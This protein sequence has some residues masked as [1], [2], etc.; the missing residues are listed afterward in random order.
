M[1][2]KSV[3]YTKIERFLAKFTEKIVCISE[4]ELESALNSHIA[5]R[6]KLELIPNGID[7]DAVRNATPK[8][9][10]KLQIP[11]DALVI[12]MVGRLTLQKAP[13][14]FIRAAKLIM[15][16]ISNSFFIIVG[17]GELEFETR[18]FA[19]HNHIPLLITGWTDEPY[20]YLKVFDIAV[21]L[22]RW[23][24]FGLAVAEYMAAEKIVIATKVDAIPTLIKDR[25][26]GLLVDADNPEE[27]A[28]QVKWII[29]HPNEVSLVIQNAKQTI[30]KEYNVSRVANQHIQ[31]F[32]MMS[33]KQ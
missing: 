24:G 13:D 19:E 29:N 3:F 12:G 22:S 9:R 14:V 20:S 15:N 23:E 16:S 26:N 28:D 7:V 21:L 17:S 30:E 27:V 33:K 8:M 32:K 5:S 6:E 2:I 4:A 10:S 25:V 18:N 31:L 1:G 11:E